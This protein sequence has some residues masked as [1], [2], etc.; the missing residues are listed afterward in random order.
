MQFMEVGAW[1]GVKP[2]AH[3]KHLRG[4]EAPLFHGE[5]CPLG[6]FRRRLAEGAPAP[7]SPGKFSA[8]SASMSF[9]ALRSRPARFHHRRNT[10]P[11]TEHSLHFSPY[12]TRASHH[13]F[14]HPVNDIFLENPQVPIDVQIFLERL[15]FETDLIRHVADRN[16]TKIRQPGFRAHRCELRILDH[17]FVTRKLVGPGLDVGKRRV[18]SG[19]GVFFGVAWSLGHGPL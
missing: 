14:Q 11:R 15:Q 17:N 12:R 8:S 7:R 10:S 4:A 1:Q 16:H 13:I 9:F 3:P 6:F 18:Q 2:A 5:G 19:L